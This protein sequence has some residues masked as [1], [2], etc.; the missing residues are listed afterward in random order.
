MAGFHQRTHRF[1]SFNIFQCFEVLSGFRRLPRLR[2]PWKLICSITDVLHMP[3]DRNTSELRSLCE[4]VEHL[5][6]KYGDSETCLDLSQSLRQFLIQL[7]R[8]ETAKARQTLLN[9][10]LAG[11]P[12][13]TDCKC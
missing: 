12:V 10:W 6:L 11:L 7:R 2:N 4:K 5:F 8:V 3:V 13:G 9:E 1:P